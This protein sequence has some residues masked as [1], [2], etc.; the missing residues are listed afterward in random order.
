MEQLGKVI[1]MF[2]GTWIVVILIGFLLAWF[3][4]LLWNITMPDVFGLP[5]ITYKQMFALYLLIKILFGSNVSFKNN[6]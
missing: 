4:M 5:E 3:A 1:G 2:V 6:N